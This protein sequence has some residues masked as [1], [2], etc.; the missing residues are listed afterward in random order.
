MKG[1]ARTLLCGA[2]S[3]CAFLPLWAH[4]QDT[5][6]SEPAGSEP[7]SSEQE[8]E[9]LGSDDT[10]LSDLEQLLDQSIVTSASRSAERASA[11]PATVLSIT[12]DELRV[13]GIRT[14][15]EALAYLG[16]GAMVSRAR[17]YYTGSDVGAQGVVLRD[18]GR[19]VLVLVDGHVM[20]AQDTSHSVLH[21]GLGVP[22]E[23][24]DHVEV[25]L[26]AGSVVYGSSAMLAVVHVFTRRG[27]DQRGLRA[28]AE[29]VVQPPQGLDGQPALPTSRGDRPGLRYRLGLGGAHTF[30]LLGA[31]AEI[32]VDGE[33]MEELS[34]SYRVPEYV[35]DSS[36]RYPG[37]AAWGGAATH[38]MRAPSAVATLRV[39][40]FR[41]SILANHYEREMPFVGTFADPIAR[42]RRSAA[43]VELRHQTLL[44]PHVTLTTRF[45]ADYTHWSEASVYT[46]DYWCLPGQVDGCSFRQAS[47]GRSAGAEQQLVVDWN[48]DG[49]LVST[50]GYDL[51][52]R[53]ATLRPADYVDRVTG[54]PP[55]TT[56]TPYHHQVSLLFAVFAQ[57][58]WRPIDWLTLN[59][60]LRLDVDTLSEAH[61]SP[62]IAAVVTPV[63]GTTLRA[64]YAEAFRAPSAYELYENDLTY[65]A[66][67][68]TLGPEIAR[69]VELE[70]QQRLEWLTLSL[71]GYV[72]F[73]EGFIDT[74]PLSAEEFEAAYARGEFA[75]TVEGE[76][77]ARWDNLNTLR[78][79]GG[80][81]AIS[82]RPVEGLVLGASFAVGHT[83]RIEGAEE[84]ELPL[85]PLWSG[86]ARVAWTLAPR[87][88]TLALAATFSGERLAFDD[89]LALAPHRLGESLD[90]RLT[91][92]A[93]LDA[94]PGLSLRTSLSY[95][96]QPLQ[97]Y[98]LSAPSEIDPSYPLAYYP[99][100]G[101]FYGLLGVQYVVDP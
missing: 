39:G 101:A 57:Q 69:S 8:S 55:W 2:L 46:L 52:G 37:M 9:Q 51:R 40:D 68:G 45:Y 80:S 15:E 77:T 13:Y 44:D 18:S 10:S 35:D 71:R 21:E 63:E 16:V 38:S 27:A 76:Y 30:Q 64:S 78:T 96:V 73:Y 31:E 24:I 23:A 89:V 5:P 85:V 12:G 81:L 94:L 70:W 91:F 98:L 97:P 50:L 84:L 20:N 75:S 99:T 43:R 1:A 33:W 17:D 47:R 11:A 53:D 28:T 56:R 60:G 32:R 29:V 93:P 19:H 48:L 90:L 59:A 49:S 22:L 34:G 7:A 83:R 74:R 58:V 66:P 36:Q 88:A 62:R 72:S 54:D 26:G 86:N 4:A 42:E 92:T 67:A 6:G 79:I 14:I 41:L 61:L 100:P 87:G 65:R 25:L 82:A 3:A 95:A